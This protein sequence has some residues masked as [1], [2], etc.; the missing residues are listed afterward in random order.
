MCSSHSATD[1]QLSAGGLEK[2]FVIG[3]FIF[4]AFVSIETLYCF[5]ANLPNVPATSDGH[6]LTCQLFKDWV[7]LSIDMVLS[8]IYLAIFGAFANS[9]ARLRIVIRSG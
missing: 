4:F 7:S 6:N 8:S 9:N 5:E 3:I 2:R 1:R